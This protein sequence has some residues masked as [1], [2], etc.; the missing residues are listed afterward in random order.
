MILTIPVLSPTVPGSMIR[1]DG[2]AIVAVSVPPLETETPIPVVSNFLDPLWLSSTD[3]PSVPFSMVAVLLPL[4][5]LTTLP[6]SLKSPAPTSW[7]ILL[8]PSW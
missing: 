3:P 4:L 8:L 2:P 7:M 1:L 6:A 5:S